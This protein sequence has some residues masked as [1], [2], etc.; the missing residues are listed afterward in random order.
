MIFLYMRPASYCLL[1]NA[2]LVRRTKG[3][4]ATAIPRL[5]RG[6]L[7]RFQM[8]PFPL[9]AK[10][11][12]LRSNPAPSL[13][14]PCHNPVAILSTLLRY[15]NL[16]ATLPTLTLSCKAPTFCYPSLSCPLRV[17]C[18]KLFSAY[19]TRIILCHFSPAPC[20]PLACILS[21]ARFIGHT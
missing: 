20:R 4:G 12:T 16:A 3:V 21:A 5:V 19:A 17:H 2:S 15:F 7:V 18:V 11:T 1:I 8:P 14:Q 13:F 10:S 9:A 6:F